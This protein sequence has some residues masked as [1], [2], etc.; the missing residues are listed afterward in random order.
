MAKKRTYPIEL[1]IRGKDLASAAIAKVGRALSFPMKALSG[2]G[3]FIEKI[4]G[5]TIAGI[6]LS[7]VA[8]GL[9]DL[10]MGASDFGSKFNDL[11]AQTGIGTRALQ[12]VA[13]AADQ[14]GVPFEQFTAGLQKMTAT[15]GKGVG[16]RQ[17]GMLG[18]NARGFAAALKKAPDTGARFELVLAQMAAI[19]DATKRAAFGMTFFGR[20]GVKLAGL[21]GQGADGIKALREE[22]EKLGLVM[23]DEEVKRAD[24]FG[25]TWAALGKVFESG[26]RDLGTGLIEG[27][28]PDMKDLLGNVKANR[29]EIGAM[30]KDLGRDVGHGL[31]DVAHGLKDAFVWA[32]G[33]VEWLAG[34]S[35]VVAIGG[36][37]ALLATNPFFAAIAG[38]VA[39]VKWLQ[40]Q[41]APAQ[42]Q[43][44]ADKGFITGVKKHGALGGAMAAMETSIR[45]Q[46]RGVGAMMGLINAGLAVRDQDQLMAE[47]QDRERQRM[48]QQSE[49]ENAVLR[50]AAAASRATDMGSPT[51]DQ[52]SVDVTV[53]VEDPGG[54][55]SGDPTVKA[56][57]GVS[58]KAKTRGNP[59]ARTTSHLRGP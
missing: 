15:I 23:N 41:K 27:L 25:D 20:S 30:L 18:K 28:L 51:W 53:T 10:A 2:L 22:A 49:A 29:K 56:T 57:K 19:P 42:T 39:A 4:P 52:Q 44:E 48:H 46:P 45:E 55:T 12:E 17:L 1:V 13:F 3:G 43:S 24:E 34:N 26:K 8:T 11:A 50:M 9:K 5:L 54:L 6:E 16:A 32:K 14:A 38:L 58:A 35:G 47:A 7:R 36:A 31:I 37:L 40:D 21:A 33:A 59:G